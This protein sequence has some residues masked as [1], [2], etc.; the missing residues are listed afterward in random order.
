MLGMDNDGGVRR[1]V[2]KVLKE[3]KLDFT[4]REKGGVLDFEPLH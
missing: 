4:K 2:E 1:V 3:S